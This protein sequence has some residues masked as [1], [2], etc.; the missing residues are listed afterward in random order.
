MW[1]EAPY[2]AAK[3]INGN[4]PCILDEGVANDM[5]RKATNKRICFKDAVHLIRGHLFI[6][7]FCQQ[8][9]VDQGE[10]H[11]EVL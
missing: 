5:V 9:D 11:H 4:L 2:E 1:F 10:A 3:F 8:F 7:K 6:H